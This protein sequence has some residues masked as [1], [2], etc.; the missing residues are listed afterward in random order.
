LHDGRG[1]L[2]LREIRACIGMTDREGDRTLQSLKRKGLIK[3]IAIMR[4]WIAS[5]D[6]P[7]KAG[8]R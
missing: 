4:G 1:A 5:A 2:T 7:S 3:Y 6:R 8:K